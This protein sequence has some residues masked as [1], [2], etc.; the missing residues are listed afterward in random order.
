MEAGLS[1]KGARGMAVKILDP[2]L[3]SQG[4]APCALAPHQSLME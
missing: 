3:L 2:F 1:R 4:T